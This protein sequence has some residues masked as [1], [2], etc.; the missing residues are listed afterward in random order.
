MHTHSASP[1]TTIDLANAPTFS[2]HNIPSQL[3]L[4]ESMI[5][6][7]APLCIPWQQ[8]V[9]DHN[10]TTNWPLS[11]YN[12]KTTI[13]DEMH[14][15]SFH[16]TRWYTIDEWYLHKTCWCDFLSLSLSLSLSLCLS[17][18]SLCVCVSIIFNQNCKTYC[19]KRDDPPIT[20]SS[21]GK[22]QQP[23]FIS[24]TITVH[25]QSTG[26]QRLVASQ[27]NTWPCNK[28][29]DT[30]DVGN[31]Y[32]SQIESACLVVEPSQLMPLH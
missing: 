7:L 21:N 6:W 2:Q 31:R 11:R 1:L 12:M 24:T 20:T 28:D 30:P 23:I 4:L 14:T 27:K 8:E 13:L 25:H 17:L 29:A 19:E 26:I 9:V 32:T 22:G 18:S 10:Q 5:T 15:I 16:V 3:S